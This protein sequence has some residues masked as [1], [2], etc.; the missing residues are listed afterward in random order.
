MV[1]FLA[2]FIAAIALVV[3]SLSLEGMLYL[4]SAG[5]LLLIADLLCLTGRCVWR[6]T[7][8]PAH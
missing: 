3:I 8:R 1:V 2:L 7:H 6:T 5:V 4:M